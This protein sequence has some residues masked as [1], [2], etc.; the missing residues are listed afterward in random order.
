MTRIFKV[1]VVSVGAVIL[2]V[3]NFDN[4]SDPATYK[5]AAVDTM[6]AAD[7]GPVRVTTIGEPA[8]GSDAIPEV[9]V[10]AEIARSNSKWATSTPAVGG[11]GSLSPS[12]NELSVDDAMALANGYQSSIEETVPTFDS[13][14]NPI[15]PS[16][17][18]SANEQDS[19]AGTNSAA[20]SLDDQQLDEFA[21]QIRYARDE[22]S[23]AQVVSTL[24]HYRETAAADLLIETAL[25]TE[26]GIRKDSVEILWRFAADG[27]ESSQYDGIRMALENAKFDL[28]PNVAKTAQA[29]IRD[30]DALAVQSAVPT[31]IEIETSPEPCWS[32]DCKPSL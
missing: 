20:L 25:S 2:A 8:S 7:N 12:G 11:S 27:I 28:N 16:D 1:T 21:Y 5:S 29:A 30:L 13:D 4:A 19:I 15:A 26:A 6:A 14:G 23:V 24:S 22:A 9:E 32:S 18:V 31:P 10:P 3:A 17:A